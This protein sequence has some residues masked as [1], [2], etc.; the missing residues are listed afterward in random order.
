MLS[1]SRFLEVTWK[2]VYDEESNSNCTRYFPTE[3][4][5]NSYYISIYVTWM[6]LVFMYIIPFATLAIFNLLTWLE[7]RR[8]IARRAHLS[9]QERKEHNLATMLLVVVL[10]FFTCNLL[11]LVVNILELFAI[12]DQQLIQVSNFLVTINSSV[13]ILIYC[14]FGKKFRTVFMQIFFGKQPP[15]ILTT[16]RSTHHAHLIGNGNGNPSSIGGGPSNSLHPEIVPLNTYRYSNGQNCMNSRRN[17]PRHF[18]IR[19]DRRESHILHHNNGS[20]CSDTD[21]I[22][23]ANDQKSV[24][25][26]AKI[27]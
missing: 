7:M 27:L 8:A 13:N 3:L 19:I 5:M 17:S 23:Y 1:N 20:D 25:V 21:A 11:P 24:G 22:M 12:S 6:Y 18:T 16:S 4:R 15:C 26:Q 10:V 2:Q 9:T 14:I